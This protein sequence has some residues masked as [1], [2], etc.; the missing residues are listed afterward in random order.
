MDIP[1]TGDVWDRIVSINFRPFM[2]GNVVLLAS[3]LFLF[4]GPAPG[5]ILV[6]R[7]LQGAAGALL[8]ISGLA[9]LI[10]HIDSDVLG[11][12]MGYM[13]LAMTMGELIGSFIGGSLY[14]HL[15]HW[16]VFGVTEGVIVIDMVLRVLIREPKT[17]RTRGSDSN[18]YEASL[19][20]EVR[21]LHDEVCSSTSSQ[22]STTLTLHSGKI[23]TDSSAYVE[24]DAAGLEAVATL[25][26]IRWNAIISVAFTTVTGIVRYTL[27]ATIPLYVL[28]HFSWNSTLGGAA[29]FALLSPA[30][31]SPWI[32]RYA[33]Q[34]GPRRLSLYAFAATGCLLAALGVFPLIGSPP[35]TK[36]SRFWVVKEVLFMLDVFLVGVSVAISTTAHM[37][38]HSAFAQKG[39]ELLAARLTTSAAHASNDDD[40]DEGYQNPLGGGLTWLTSGVLLA[41]N[42]TAWGLGMFLGPLAA[43]LIGFGSDAEW[44]RLCWFLAGLSWLAALGIG[45]GWR[46]N[47][48]LFPQET[49]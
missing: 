22:N 33:T 6:A 10:S 49:A 26:D 9:F 39:D 46:E 25:K 13:T 19:N 4:L 21:L 5:Y 2:L 15:G 41:G 17:P 20:E 7:A 43:N 28:R 48:E 36:T 24:I 42:S 47:T 37:T 31:L 8:Y 23:A 35:T 11:Y 27:E 12:Y 1:S 38:T 18:K 14:E 32:G 16:A 29:I 34:H 45:L 40:N 3:I 30:V 44:L